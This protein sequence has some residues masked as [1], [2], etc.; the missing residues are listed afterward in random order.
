MG[1]IQ[2]NNGIDVNA[3]KVEKECVRCNVIYM[4]WENGTKTIKGDMHISGLCDI[5]QFITIID[6]Y[7]E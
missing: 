4:G 7:G 2:Y 1:N 3:K 6:P 5:C